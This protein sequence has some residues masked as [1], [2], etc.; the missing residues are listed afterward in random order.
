MVWSWVMTAPVPVAENATLWTASTV[1]ATTPDCV[2]PGDGGEVS[3]IRKMFHNDRT[4]QSVFMACLFLDSP[5]WQSDNVTVISKSVDFPKARFFSAARRF[6]VGAGSSIEAR[7]SR[8]EWTHRW[9]TG[10]YITGLTTTP[11]RVGVAPFS[12]KIA[13]AEVR[14][15]MMAKGAGIRLRV[16]FLP[17]SGRYPRLGLARHNALMTSSTCAFRHGES[18]VDYESCHTEGQ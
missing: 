10:G 17:R 14:V 3:S 8:L 2:S 12:V 13:V 6:D 4:A 9:A 5:F 15:E 1:P 7:G 18:F 16:V 11:G